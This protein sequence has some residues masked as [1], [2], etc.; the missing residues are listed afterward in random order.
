M[1]LFLGHL[2][3]Q[4]CHYATAAPVLMAKRSVIGLPSSRVHSPLKRLLV[5][6]FGSIC[7]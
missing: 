3:S 6:S 1:L 4:T 5:G 2:P 7:S